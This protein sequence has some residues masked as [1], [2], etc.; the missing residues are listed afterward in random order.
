L[1]LAGVLQ[2]AGALMLG[3][4]TSQF[5]MV[6]AI[7]LLTRLYDAADFGA[8]AVFTA[9]M[10]V[11]AVVATG[12]YEF[13][14][15]LPEQ[16]EEA[17]SVALVGI[18]IAAGM[19]LLLAL[20][21]ALAIVL[22][23]FWLAD[24]GLLPSIM[25]L[26]LSVFFAA[27][28][29]V[30]Q[31]WNNRLS[32]YRDMARNQVLQALLV[33][34][35]SLLCGLLEIS[36]GLIIGISLGWALAAGWAVYAAQRSSGLFGRPQ[37]AHFKAM[38]RRYRTHAT[39]IAP[40]QLLGVIAVQLPVLLLSS[41]YSASLAGYYSVAYRVANLPTVLM[42]NALGEVYR[43]RIS[44]GWYQE[45]AFSRLFLRLLLFF[46]LFGV[47][48]FVG[49]YWIS[50]WLFP[51]V[52]GPEWIDA[53]PIAKVLLLGAYSN[54]VFTPLDKGA[55]VVG[56]TRYMVCWQLLRFVIFVMICVWAWLG[57]P[58]FMYLL[59]S[60]VASGIALNLISGFYEYR[61]S[62]GRP[63]QTV[64]LQPSGTGQ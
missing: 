4:A 21:C 41:A 60:L 47:P 33:V 29:A 27:V 56:A 7:P 14:V 48:V 49:L 44:E 51:L 36:D 10:G 58:S 55:M 22:L 38:A 30:V 2:Q 32:A 25:L 24:L 57:A 64:P 23:P 54:F 42:A 43:Q 1:K 13:A 53:V 16:R 9:L 6:G 45:G 20:L 12:R 61:L 35:F 37:R 15:I 3:N 19:S 63:G 39:S 62:L 50:P 28:F 46:S 11:L 31:V 40:S 34:T 8:S 26:P 18:A 17:K 59:W 5:V 52:L